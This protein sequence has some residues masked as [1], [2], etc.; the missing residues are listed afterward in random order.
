MSNEKDCEE[1]N[2]SGESEEW[3]QDS[4]AGDDEQEIL[5]TTL[6]EEKRRNQ[7]KE[8]QTDPSYGISDLDHY[9][10]N[11]GEQLEMIAL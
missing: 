1:A 10:M 8:M 4:I 9:D 2:L 7:D 11:G 6:A 3:E 5:C